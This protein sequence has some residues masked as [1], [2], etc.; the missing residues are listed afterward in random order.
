M[1]TELGDKS[2]G[3]REL[4]P[5][6]ASSEAASS[7]CSGQLQIVP[8]WQVNGEEAGREGFRKG[9]CVVLS[10]QHAKHCRDRKVCV[11]SSETVGSSECISVS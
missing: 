4:V 5:F 9:E 3:E 11:Q 10:L 7:C 1:N 6:L 2:V 8:S